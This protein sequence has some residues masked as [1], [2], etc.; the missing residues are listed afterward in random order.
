MLCLHFKECIE[1]YHSLIDLDGVFFEFTAI[2]VST[3]DVEGS[4]HEQL[5]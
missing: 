1:Y 2:A 3:E 4:L 5:K